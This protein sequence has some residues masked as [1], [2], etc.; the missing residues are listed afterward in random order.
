MTAMM[1]P[2]AEISS[3]LLVLGLG[4]ILCGDDG[5]GAAAV[6]RLGL[7]FVPP[8]GVRLADGGTLGLS[9]LPYIEDAADVILVDAIRDGADSPAGAFVRIE[10]DEVAPAVR[11]RLSVHQIGV[12]D[13]L[14]SA[15]LCDRFPRRLVLLGLVP[16]TLDLGVGLS[17][18]VE[19][20]IDEL[21]E[22]IVQ[23]AHALGYD[24]A[25]RP[26]RPAQNE[27]RPNLGTALD[28]GGGHGVSR[29]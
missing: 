12:F 15:R 9:L 29:L 20:R 8:E 21:V 14:S 17:A 10:D 22:R 2:F 3:R 4:N 24:F 19:A 6:D 1:A 27:P 23:E 25:A 26:A 11:D 18:P 5:L 7:R 28:D 16:L 13:L